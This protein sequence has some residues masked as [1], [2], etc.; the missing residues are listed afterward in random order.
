M[1][2]ILI[3]ID[4]GCLNNVYSNNPDIE[5]CLFDWDEVRYGNRKDIARYLESHR[6]LV[7][8][9]PETVTEDN[10]SLRNLEIDTEKY[11]H[12]VW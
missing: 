12:V 6:N 2:K 7:R 10:F 3:E 9:L 11:P 8:G 4:G 1:T 5:V